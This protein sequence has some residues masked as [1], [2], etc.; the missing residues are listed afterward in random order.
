M[1]S[2]GFTGPV[3]VLS[4]DLVLVDWGPMTLTIAVWDKGRARPV[5]AAQAARSSLSVLKVLA[6]FQNFLKIKVGEI[7]PTGP[8]PVVVARAFEAAR[9]SSAEL[10]PL[11][12]VAG[13]VADQV[14]ETAAGLGADRVIVNNG[15]DIAVRLRRKEQVMVGLKAPGQKELLGRL[16]LQAGSGLGG[17]ASSGWSGRSFSPGVADLVTVWGENAGLAD[18]AATHIAGKTTVRVGAVRRARAR[19]L[20]SSS[21]LG[22]TLVTVTVGRLSP[23]SRQEAL[24]AGLAA[25]EEQYRSHCIRGCF[26]LVQG[27]FALLDADGVMTLSPSRLA[28]YRSG[29]DNYASI[30]FNRP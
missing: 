12:A 9:A 18:A 5:M 3:R 6:D 4:P 20:D 17:V 28:R 29:I 1:D 7:S 23:S 10:T 13:A 30:S 24:T 26:I 14:A 8:L 2:A 27:D 16:R 22:D 15:G 11:A 21:D 25:A 19:D